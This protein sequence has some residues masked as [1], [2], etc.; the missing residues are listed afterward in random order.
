[1][2][3]VQRTFG[4][5]SGHR[6]EQKSSRHQ[7]G[8][9]TRSVRTW[10][11]PFEPHRVNSPGSYASNQLS[12]T[13]DQSPHYDLHNPE[14]RQQHQQL[15]DLMHTHLKTH[16]EYEHEVEQTSDSRPLS[17]LSDLSLRSF[18][19][20]T[21]DPTLDTLSSTTHAPS[22][23]YDQY[24][25][26]PRY[27]LENLALP[28][29]TYEHMEI[30]G[31]FNTTTRCSSGV[32]AATNVEQSALGL[33]FAAEEC[34]NACCRRKHEE[35]ER[36]PKQFSHGYTRS[37]SVAGIPA[38][39]NTTTTPNRSNC[40]RRD[41]PSGEDSNLRIKWITESTEYTSTTATTYSSL[42]DSHIAN[43]LNDA[44]EPS[45][46]FDLISPRSSH[47]AL[48]DML[49]QANP[50]TLELCDTSTTQND[51]SPALQQ[52][53]QTAFRP[54][55]SSDASHAHNQA[56]P[57]LTHRWT[58]E[59]QITLSTLDALSARPFKLEQTI[60]GHTAHGSGRW[61]RFWNHR[62]WNVKS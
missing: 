24:T 15:S 4:F 36:L 12:L 62:R 38:S 39:P 45:S 11:D 52:S 1:M 50:G 53:A 8:D 13:P 42:D 16:K 25:D 20:L 48:D 61:S 3:W 41:N 43:L 60:Q 9:D 10:S 19:D 34:P 31:D 14:M 37:A 28:A 33:I 2:E 40:E 21:P 44:T 30:D 55:K 58:F 47:C 6:Y 49:Q 29:F 35:P 7:V 23:P 18:L 56:H 46:V 27:S 51:Y 54:S 17:P 32:F 22:T 57:E 26:A 5:N 59:E